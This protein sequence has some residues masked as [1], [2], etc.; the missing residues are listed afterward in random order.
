M[1]AP[2]SSWQ[3]RPTRCCDC[4]RAIELVR[5]G[6]KVSAG[7]GILPEF[8]GAVC[9]DCLVLADG[10]LVSDFKAEAAVHFIHATHFELKTAAAVQSYL[11]L[12]GWEPVIVAAG[13]MRLHADG[14]P[15]DAFALLK[16]A[17]AEGPA[18]YYDVE[19]AALLLIDGETG[20]AHD[21][22]TATTAGDHPKWHHWNGVLA[23]SVGRTEAAVEHWRLQLEAQ[24]EDFESWLPLGFHLMQDRQDYP[25]A[26]AYFRRACERHPAHQEFRAWLGDALLRQDRCDEALVE[27][28]AA[29][30]L[31]PVDERFAAGI[32]ELI[33]ELDQ[34]EG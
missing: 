12:F 13:A 24:P 15:R 10:M 27:L 31:K 8:P 14:K 25:A 3:P 1:P 22:L 18:G 11:D 33:A 2:P 9:E 5:D 30:E 16:A 4:G 19:R 34:G 28:K 21:L 20:Q 29:R 7:G 32:E 23:H 6:G 17:R 26:E